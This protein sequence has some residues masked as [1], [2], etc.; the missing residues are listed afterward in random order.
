MTRLV[1]L[2]GG[3]AHALVLLKLRKFIAKH[4]EVT[5]VTPSPLHTYSGM[6]PGIVAGHYA[7]AVAQIDLA[8]LA[9]GA[10]A[11]LIQGR[12]VQIDP[13]AKR[14]VLANG[15]TLAYDV[16]SLN[17]GSLPEYGGVAGALEQAIAA[18]PFEGFLALWRDLLENGPRAPR[19]A[20]VGA[21]AGGVELAMAMQYALAS[22]GSGGLVV[23]YADKNVFTLK[24]APRI[25]AAL[26]RLGVE[27]R[28][29]M[30]VSALEPGPTVVSPAGSERFDAVFWAT[31]AAPLP[32]LRESG[33]MTDA[34]GYVRV[35]ANLQSVSHP[36]VFAA[37]DTA[38]PAG[39]TLPK[40]G[41]HAVRQGA[42]LADNLQRVVRGTA[43]LDY[44][45]QK[46][47]LSLISCGEKYAIASRGDW[48]AEGAWAWWW[49]DWL[50]QR[51][52]RQFR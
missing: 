33:L 18:K 9:Q 34:R 28:P 2:G 38:S 40:S 50:D 32:M 47:S 4:L 23:I 46:A 26:Q 39:A 52:I 11:E 1:L 15:A 25:A 16:L 36:D 21:G 12:A 31:G 29:A 19:I 5:L 20:V 6:V 41:V 51:W 17:L 42:V 27:L 30:P 8:R 49:K 48:S 22:R 43:L 35:N 14:M 37:G 44:V 45:A 24:V 3:H 7:S 10:S 13:A